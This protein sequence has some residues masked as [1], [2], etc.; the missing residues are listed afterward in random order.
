MLELKVGM[1]KA[2]PFK[3]W[4]KVASDF[5]WEE[6]PKEVLDIMLNCNA[7]ALLLGYMRPIVANVTNSS[8]FPTYNLPFM[9]FKEE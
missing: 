3:L 1:D 4:I 8:K 7:P 9:N 6:L 5:V 2:A